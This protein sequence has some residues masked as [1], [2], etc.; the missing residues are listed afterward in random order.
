MHFGTGKSCAVLCRDRLAARRDALDTTSTTRTTQG[1]RHSVDRGGT[2]LIPEVGE[3]FFLTML[4]MP[5]EIRPEIGNS[6]V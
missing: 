5:A 4:N 6:L 3:R 1:R 2:S